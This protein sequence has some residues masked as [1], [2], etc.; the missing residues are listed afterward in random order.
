[1]S[2][3]NWTILSPWCMHLKVKAEHCTW[4]AVNLRKGQRFPLELK[5]T[6]LSHLVYLRPGHVPDPLE[7]IAGQ[8]SR[9]NSR[10]GSKVS[11]GE[12]FVCH[13]SHH[14]QVCS[15]RG[16]S[17]QWLLFS[18]LLEVHREGISVVSI[19]TAV[20]CEWLGIS[21][22]FYC[23]TWPLGSSKFYLWGLKL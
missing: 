20:W 19:A 6:G 3:H 1:M 17:K 8:G 12:Y 2:A 21:K 23:E 4:W 14:F 9:H 22:H 11:P 7:V 16:F 15:S 13:M 5:K 10:R 18:Q